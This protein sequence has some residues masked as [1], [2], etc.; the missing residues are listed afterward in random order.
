MNSWK[1]TGRRL[2][3]GSRLDF[4][5][6]PGKRNLGSSQSSSARC[7]RQDVYNLASR[8][9]WFEALGISVLA[10]L[11][12]ILCMPNF[13]V[14]YFQ[15]VTLPKQAELHGRLTIGRVWPKP[16]GKETGI[17][18]SASSQEASDLLPD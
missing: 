8:V 13:A 11:M 7:P 9:Q 10:S 1:L 6:G 4:Q 16:G 15:I 14:D 3:R 18:K 12:V 5:S 17:G 2:A